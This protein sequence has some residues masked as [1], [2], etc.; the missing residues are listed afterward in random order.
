LTPA[1]V[2]FFVP[3]HFKKKV[4]TSVVIYFF[5]TRGIFFLKKKREFGILF[6]LGVC[7]EKKMKK[8]ILRTPAGRITIRGDP[9]NVWHL[10]A[11]CQALEGIGSILPPPR[12]PLG[13]MLTHLYDTKESISSEA[14]ENLILNFAQRL[15]RKY[16][17]VKLVPDIDKILSVIK[18]MTLNLGTYT[19]T[20]CAGHGP[21][22]EEFRD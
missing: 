20:Y 6:F 3:A 15:R 4:G 11:Y 5:L 13:V 16:R 18:N 8:Y 14:K 10:V 7:S 22:M 19:A 12:D 2:F 1:I 21:R 9:D 17:M